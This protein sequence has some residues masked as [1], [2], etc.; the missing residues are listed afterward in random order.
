MEGQTVPMSCEEVESALH[1]QA[2]KIKRER[3][4][5]FW[6][7]DVPCNRSLYRHLDQLANGLYLDKWQVPY[8]LDRNSQIVDK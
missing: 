6:G 1:I 4:N 2:N 7:L 3:M 5:P 8:F